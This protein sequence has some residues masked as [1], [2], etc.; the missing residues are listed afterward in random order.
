MLK[1]ILYIVV[2]V[3]LLESCIFREPEI[4]ALCLRD[5]IGNYVIKWETDP[6]M[7]G[8]VRID[9]SDDPN[10][11]KYSYSIGQVNIADGVTTH[12]TNGNTTQKYFRLVFNGKYPIIIG[13]RLV[14]MEGIQNFRDLGGYET[15]DGKTTRWAKI[16]RSGHLNNIST[17]DSVRLEKLGIRT[18]IDL[19]TP[20]EVDTAAIKGTLAKVVS[21]PI[22]FG[23]DSDVVKDV[24]NGRM[25]K[26][27]ALVFLQDEYLQFVTDNT[28]QFA[29][30]IDVLLDQ[31]NYPVLFS[32]SFGKDRAGFLSALL[33]TAL[34][35]EWDDVVED[36]LASNQYIDTEALGDLVK[37]YPTDVQESLTVLITANEGILKLAF[38]KIRK[39]YGSFHDYQTKGLRLSDKKMDLL[40]DM[41]L[42]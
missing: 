17:W 15:K 28:E 10:D 42:Y 26:G 24:L 13:S 9:V 39:E 19:R 33:L 18:I 34:G 27:D 35:V 32:C 40:K 23:R 11:F 37:G 16:Y 38:N 20:M 2:S 12:I 5:E 1:E 14:N 41:L 8:K 31:Q 3:C 36:Y 29:K 25:R 22:S 6:A 7:S 30:V 21:I 4:D